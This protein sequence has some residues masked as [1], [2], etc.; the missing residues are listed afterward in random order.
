[1]GK[2]EG[3]KKLPPVPKVPYQSSWRKKTKGELVHPERDY[4]NEGG[5]LIK[6]T[7]TS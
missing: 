5:I 3:L 1:L 2:R 6:A 7:G 4:E